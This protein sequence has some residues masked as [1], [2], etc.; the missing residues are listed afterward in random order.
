MSRRHL[1]ALYILIKVFHEDTA[2]T[3]AKKQLL[4]KPLEAHRQ[5]ET[6]RPSP[7]LWSGYSSTE[8]FL[9]LLWLLGYLRIYALHSSV[10]PA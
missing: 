8:Q 2:Q 4:L 7:L 9:T 10:E 1:S 3:I 6:S 5:T